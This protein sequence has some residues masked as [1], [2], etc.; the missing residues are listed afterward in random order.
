M[1][2]INLKQCIL[3]IIFVEMILLFCNIGISTCINF[4]KFQIIKS[5]SVIRIVNKISEFLNKM[6][7]CFK[8]KNDS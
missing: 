4:T 7:T 8:G 5:I 6:V 1:I 3:N 2:Q